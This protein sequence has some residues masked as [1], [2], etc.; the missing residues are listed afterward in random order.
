MYKMW[1]RKNI[2]ETYRRSILNKIVMLSTELAVLFQDC[3]KLRQ[4]KTNDLYYLEIAQNK[5]STTPTIAI[6][7]ALL[8]Q[9]S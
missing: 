7:I 1:E 4:Y 9:D 3:L 2:I 8:Y 5:D 6:S